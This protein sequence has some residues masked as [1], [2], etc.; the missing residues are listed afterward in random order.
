MHAILAALTASALL[1][2]AAL[3]DDG[4]VVVELFTSQGCSSC[5]P[6]HEILD[7]LAAEPEII[8]LALH[9]DYWDYL[10]W[11]DSFGS[12]QNSERQQAYVRAAGQR[13][14]YTPQFIV[15]GQDHIIGAKA[16][17]VMSRIMAHEGIETGV[18]L[19]VERNGD[20]HLVSLTSVESV[21]MVVQ[22]VRY[23][24]HQDVEVLGGENAGRQLSYSNIVT[25][26]DIIADWDGAG[27][28]TLDVEISGSDPAVLIVQRAGAG[29]IL[30]AARFDR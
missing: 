15:E 22:L 16:M 19:V 29:P 21:P 20:L 12:A 24:P 23:L 30:A 10:G 14:V 3:A 2:G 4:P 27:P 13:T 9:V 5:P 28:L 1:S 18:D 25:R 8:A 17:E 6:A 11:R 26:W 7:L